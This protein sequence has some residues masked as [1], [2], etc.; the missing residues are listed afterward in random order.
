M[1]K[2]CAGVRKIKLKL[3]VKHTAMERNK[4]KNAQFSSN[5]EEVPRDFCEMGHSNLTKNSKV[6]YNHIL[7][8]SLKRFSVR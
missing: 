3:Q 6:I 4:Q 8:N 5:T 7:A 2:I 1:N